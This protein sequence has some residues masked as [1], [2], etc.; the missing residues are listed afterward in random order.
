MLLSQAPDVSFQIHDVSMG[1]GCQEAQAAAV[2]AL[3]AADSSRG[4]ELYQDGGLQ[5]SECHWQTVP[6]L[7]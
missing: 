5:P 2:L 6:A 7:A 3:C 1:C 4:S